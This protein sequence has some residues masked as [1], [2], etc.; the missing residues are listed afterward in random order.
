MCFESLLKAC[1]RLLN[2]FERP[3]EKPFSGLLQMTISECKGGATYRS[4]KRDGFRIRQPPKQFGEGMPQ[5]L[6]LPSV[7]HFTEGEKMFESPHPRIPPRR[8]RLF[9]RF[10]IILF[11]CPQKLAY[12]YRS[13]RGARE[14][15][16]LKE[17]KELIDWEW[18]CADWL[19][20]LV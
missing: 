18:L 2:A 19:T 6:A 12:E 1:A 8:P 17:G 15:L 14:G 11:R 10:P 16:I 5:F 20:W 3:L 9:L 13:T 4:S 7:S